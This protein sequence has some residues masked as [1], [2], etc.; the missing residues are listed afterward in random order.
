MQTVPTFFL[1]DDD[2]DDHEIFNHAMKEA[3]DSVQ[4]V[5]ANDGRQAIEKIINENDF[6][7]DVIFL[8][9]NMPRLNG[10]Q[11]LAELKKI[12]RLKNIP[13]IMY[14]T[15]DNPEVMEAHLKM[16]AAEFVVK[17]ADI[18]VLTNVLKRI[19]RQYVKPI[20]MIVFLMCFFPRQSFAQVNTVTSA[21]ELKKLSMEELMNIV[22]TSVSKTPEKLSEVA[23]AIQVVTNED[24]KRSGVIRLPGA[25]RLATNLQVYSSGAHD[26]QITARGFNGFPVANSSL[27]NKLLVLIDGR[28]VYNTLF[29]GVYWDVQNVMLEDVNQVEAIS[30]PGGS[31]W[32]A[33]AVNGIIN[34][35]SK[36]ARETQ[37]LYATVAAGDQLQDYGAIR[38]GSHIDSTIFYRAYVQHFDINSATRT[39]GTDAQDAWY[40]TQGGFRFDYIPSSKSTIT[41]Q[42][43]L[44]QGEEDD[45]ASTIVNGQ[46]IIARLTH[47]L[48]DR[49]GFTVQTYFDRTYRNIQSQNSSIEVNTYDIDMQHNFLAGNRN[50]IVWGLGYRLTSDHII[51]QTTPI[52]PLDRNL[53]LYS[54]FV[55]DQIALVLERLDL[56]IGTKVLHNFYTGFEIQPT[57]R[58]AYFLNDHNTLWAAVSHAVR[59]PTRIDR[60]IPSPVIF[61]SEKLNAYELGYRVR[62][63][64]SMSFSIATFYNQYTDLRSID[65]NPAP[66][67]P[68]YFANHLEANTWG[69]EIFANVI[70][71]RWW[72][73]RGGYTWMEEEFMKTSDLTLSNGYLREAIDPNNQFLIQSIMDIAKHFQVDGTVRYVDKLPASFTIPEVEAYT[74]FDLRVAYNYKWIT[75]SVVGSNLASEKHG[76]SGITRI[77]RSY[78]GRLTIQF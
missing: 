43:D 60:D 49:A 47:H 17:P 69:V 24:I 64:N 70:A 11:C 74:T 55:Q 22:V 13:V 54:G 10:A 48:S 44:Y 71:T 36:S 29:G 78:H 72:K 39:D 28:T 46:N 56:T 6:T 30:G 5:F 62:P 33:N 58:L 53:P 14:S 38:Y 16:G 57:V 59:T 20:M 76:S 65:I 52:A 7:P 1:I 61:D 25:L 35:V 27:S 77:P 19:V 4:C 18:N 50:K 21:K 63:S 34:I 15:T 73:L 75:V 67:P 31:I 32:G 23:S 9:L 45:T 68:A 8:D 26:T 37:G 41:V 3:D 2:P 40:N 66:P 42:G 51:S 12:E